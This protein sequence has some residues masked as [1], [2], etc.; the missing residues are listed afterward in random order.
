VKKALFCILILIIGLPL[1]TQQKHALVIGNSSYVGISQLRNPV[2]DANDMETAL[3]ALG[4]T[5]EKV[6]NGSLSEMENAVLNLRRRLSGSRNS[7]GFFFFAGH[8]VE[9]GGQNFLIPVQADNIR[10]ESQ[11]RERA[12]SLQF[13]L[14]SMNEAGNELNMVVLDACRDN[15][16]SWARS[17]SRGL[18]VV[19]RAPSGSIIMYAAGAGQV[20]D[21]G[22]GRNGL[23]TTQLL[24]SLRTPGLSVMEVFSRTGEE[25]IRVSNGRQHPEISVRF[26]ST[27]FLGARPA[28]A[29]APQP[30]P[31]PSAAIVQGQNRETDRTYN[32]GDTGPAGGIIFFDKGVHSDGWRYLEAAPA[33]S[34]FRA[35]WGA[36]ERNV[37]GT[38]DA[39][40]TGRQNTRLNTESGSAA[41]RCLQLNIN[42][43]HDWFLPSRDELDLMY[44][45]L[46]QR[47]LG[48]FRTIRDDRNSTHVYWSSSQNCN[49]KG[50]GQ[51]FS[52]GYQGG[53][54]K[55]NTYSV[56]A[57]RAF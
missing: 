36:M 44:R 12:V 27:A 51:N 15:P 5:V 29:P 46:A 42:G 55:F 41:L 33:S 52:N 38:N 39:V 9:S 7:Y 47:G 37:S 40:G 25:V 23:F 24:N 1:F 31:V 53:Y 14:D 56:R 20:A 34:E 18:G 17:G 54:D 2:N 4:F 3:R 19:S 22:A 48:G 16:F 28:P 45:N 21:D 13:I 32:I 26:F 10:S 49:N 57:V 43:F 35:V 6:L 30:T 8:G 50:W 11:L